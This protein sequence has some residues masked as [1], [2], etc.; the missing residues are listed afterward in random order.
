MPKNQADTTIAD[1]DL[2]AVNGGKPEDCGG[3]SRGRGFQIGDAPVRSGPFVFRPLNAS[4][5][6]E[7]AQPAPNFRNLRARKR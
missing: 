7:K 1:Q 3:N 5:R 6:K 2:N 4:C